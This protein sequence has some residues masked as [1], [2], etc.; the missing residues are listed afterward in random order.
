MLLVAP[1]GYG[2]TTLA[3]E[4][5]R[6]KKH[7]WYQTTQASSDVAALALGLAD[8]G[9]GILPNVGARLR[10][11][12]KTVSDAAAEAE[13][14]ATDL[15]A[16]FS[17]W[18]GDTRLVV[19]DYHLLAE[20]EAA[21][22]FFE[23]FARTTSIPFLITSRTRPQWV[24]AKNLLYG[25]VSEFGR[26]AL[27]MT[28]D[29]A[30]EVL[31]HSPDAMPGLVSLAEGW[32]AVIG[33]AALLTERMGPT[34][35]EVPETLH[36]FFA[37]ELY[38]EM[39]GRL[40]WSLV[41]LS[42]GPSI[43]E[44]VTRTVFGEDGNSILQEGYR[45]GFL[46][47]GGDGYELHPLLRQF[48]RTKVPD[49]ERID[50]VATASSLARAYMAYG[51]WDE[52]ISIAEEFELSAVVLE[53]LESALDAA[54]SEGRVRS[55]ER[56][57][58]LARVATPTAPIV[59]L[60]EIEVAFRT[61]NVASA[62]DSADQ[63]ARI[64]HRGDPLASRIFLRAG[65][66]AHLDDRLEEAVKFFKAAH[67]SAIEPADLRQA[68]WSLFVTLT[69]LDD[70]KG[71]DAA[72]TALENLPP[73]RVEDLLRAS[74][75]RLQSALRWGGVVEAVEATG[76]ALELLDRSEDPVV[77][78]GF[79]QTYGV[80]SILAARYPEAGRIA[81]RE[82]DEA[83]R[84]GLEWVLPHALEMHASAA[85][86]QRDF[87]GALKTLARVRSL[88]SG[89]A[90]TE[91]NVDVLRARIYLC[92][93]APDRA[94]D[95]LRGRDGAATSPGMHGD[96]L[97]TLGL[98]LICA[99]ELDKGGAFLEK[100]EG[101]TTHL[102]ART[103]SAFG[104]A[105][106]AQLA[107][108]DDTRRQ[109]ALRR[110]CGVAIETGNFDAFVAAYRACPALLR[111]LALVEGAR[112]SFSGVVVNSDPALA[113]SFGLGSRARERRSGEPLT[114]REREVLQLVSQGL[115]NRQIARTLW[116][117]EST[118]KVHI[119]HLFEK[120]GVQSRTEAAARAAELL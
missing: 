52:A 62:R 51:R 82:I 11:R 54:L 63:L 9:N 107:D 46:S 73:L 77:R 103:L 40:Q 2:K 53:V 39:D 29:E 23:T 72:L 37:E 47:R 28:H 75:A 12:L 67:E 13:S 96:Y 58:E 27:A 36:E 10:G 50:V 84:F 38:Q 118:V 108:L 6:D 44:R 3:R 74:Q 83:Q 115:S 101:V 19:D 68:L 117:A 42:L 65:Q 105:V 69:D 55:V 71:A 41:Q 81:D 92:N 90:H 119:R 14:L 78:T 1:A 110:A 102:E 31:T 116:I 88:A 100:A 112:R 35:P 33:L 15:A 22:R 26:T 4:W 94:V 113:E 66:I 87:N 8:T 45:R 57:V 95:L 91:L 17:E 61:G 99:G 59:R 18:P 32:P 60:A 24:T 106:A 86:G 79:L 7:A 25:E 34:Q 70:R 111:D 64:T 43:D 20:N 114:R 93:G 80:A 76:N 97:A 30:A 21:E 56:W 104:R 16:D 120:L 5:L 85:A 48:L 98:C 49:F 89:N 109:E